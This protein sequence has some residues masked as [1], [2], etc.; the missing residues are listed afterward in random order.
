MPTLPTKCQQK[1][2]NVIAQKTLQH[3]CCCSTGVHSNR[4]DTD[5]STT[6]SYSSSCI[7]QEFVGVAQQPSGNMHQQCRAQP[8]CDLC[9]VFCFC[10]ACHSQAKDQAE[11]NE[12]VIWASARGLLADVSAAGQQGSTHRPTVKPPWNALASCNKHTWALQLHQLSADVL[13]RC[14]RRQRS[15]LLEEPS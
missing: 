8:A 1:V 13:I 5:T 9:G 14:K 6:L 7:V 4:Q 15:S 2:A 11:L 12:L 3:G 10:C